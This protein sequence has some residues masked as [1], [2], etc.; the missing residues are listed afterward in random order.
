MLSDMKCSLPPIGF[1][2]FKEIL[3]DLRNEGRFRNLILSGAEVTTCADLEQ[4]IRYAASL[5]WFKKIQIQTN[6]RKLADKAYVNRLI[7]NGVNEFFISIHGLEDIHDRI[8]AC[9][10][11][12]QETMAGICNLKAYPVNVI[13]NTVLT[14]YN[15]QDVPPLMR[16]LC[17]TTASE[18]HL[19]NFYPMEPTDSRDFVVSIHDFLALLGSLHPIFEAAGKP[20]VLKSFPEC[21]EAGEPTIFDSHYPVTIL[22]DRFWQKFGQSGFGKCYYRQNGECSNRDCWGLSSAYIDKYGDERDRLSPTDKNSGN[23]K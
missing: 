2:Q 19:W 1:T 7:E 17:R 6:G 18:I 8:T 13:T 11:S 14:R 9:P 20:L 12:F 23:I 22:P 4:Y 16:D 5:G 15:Y 10:V 21:L 3:I